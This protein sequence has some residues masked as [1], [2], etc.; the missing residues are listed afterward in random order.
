MKKVLLSI[1]TMLLVTALFVGCGGNGGNPDSGN[2]NNNGAT[3]ITIDSSDITESLPAVILTD[4]NWKYIQEDLLSGQKE[5]GKFTISDSKTKIT[6]TELYDYAYGQFH[7]ISVESLNSENWVTRFDYESDSV[8]NGW[9]LK[10]NTDKEHLKYSISKEKAR[11]ILLE[12][13]D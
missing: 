4:G 9:V 5:Y 11:S 8:E 2:N 1:G 12:K 13:I 6:Y 10:S 7:A 3:Q